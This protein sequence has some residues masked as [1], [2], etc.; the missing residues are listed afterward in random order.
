MPSTTPQQGMS[1][2]PLLVKELVPRSSWYRAFSPQKYCETYYSHEQ[3][4]LPPKRILLGNIDLDEDQYYVKM[5]RTKP[6][7]SN[8]ISNQSSSKTDSN[9]DT[10]EYHQVTQLA[11]A[12]NISTR[13]MPQNAYHSFE[14]HFYGLHSEEERRRHQQICYH[15]SKELL[16]IE[17]ETTSTITEKTTE[18]WKENVIENQLHNKSLVNTAT[19]TRQTQRTEGDKLKHQITNKNWCCEQIKNERKFYHKQHCCSMRENFGGNFA[20]I[21]SREQ[22]T[23]SLFTSGKATKH[24]FSRYHHQNGLYKND[25]YKFVN[26]GDKVYNIVTSSSPLINEREHANKNCNGY[27]SGGLEKQQAD[28]DVISFSSN[29]FESNIRNNNQLTLSCGSDKR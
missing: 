13:D 2:R 10:K 28:K 26:A 9:Q 20:D 6:E 21:K 14:K 3:P 16:N 19:A 27:P 18:L 11:A 7:L 12:S 23:L 8:F 25:Q 4:G 22:N 17:E 5:N 15:G 1:S 29:S 24:T